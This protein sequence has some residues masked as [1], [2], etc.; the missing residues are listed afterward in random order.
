M[1]LVAS[2]VGC[3]VESGTLP[4][5]TPTSIAGNWLLTGALP[6]L[7]PNQF[8][9]TAFGVTMTFSVAGDQIAGGGYFQAPCSPSGPFNADIGGGVVISGSANAKGSFTAQAS[10]TQPSTLSTLRLQGSVPSGTAGSWSG[11]YSF[12]SNN[13]GCPFNSSGPFTA[14]RIADV[15]G[16]YSGSTSI[17]PSGGSSSGSGRPISFTFIFQQQ[18][19]T[20]QIQAIN[21]GVLAG[22][23]QVQG[24]PCFTSGT[25]IPTQ[26]QLEGVLGSHL[27]ASFTM[28]DGSR[29]DMPADIEDVTSG[30]L[31]VIG[32]A[33]VGGACD[34]QGTGS[35]ELTRQ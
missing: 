6:F 4:A 26:P 27:L 18:Q 16:T 20:T 1:G 28:N 15:T 32:A 24:S 17:Y 2:L 13:A 5:T 3:G 12:S 35:F 30:K 9:N 34:R 21:G 11:T 10:A 14:I 23:V 29:L 8:A 22:T 31:E 19:T 7:G 33:V 25:I